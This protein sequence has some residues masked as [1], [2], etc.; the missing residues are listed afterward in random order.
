MAVNSSPYGA[1]REGTG[2][3]TGPSPKPCVYC[4][5]PIPSSST[6]CPTCK[7]HQ[8]KWRNNLVLIAGLSGFLALM[9][10][11]VTF[12][13][14]R[15]IQLYK[16]THWRDDVALLALLTGPT[17]EY[18]A[19]LSNNGDGAIFV[20]DLLI[21]WRGDSTQI[22]INK[23]IE[24]GSIVVMDTMK[25]T[26]PMYQR[27]VAN[28]EGKASLQLLQSARIWADPAGPSPPC[29]LAHVHSED[30]TA[31]RMMD[32]FY[33]QGGRRLVTDKGEANLEYF[34]PHL[35]IKNRKVFPITIAFAGSTSGNCQGIRTD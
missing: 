18:S 26:G 3:E 32:A 8:S 1:S 24:A 7:F 19:V 12:V 33:K 23:V 6:I 31:I 34:S 22:R 4:G 17:G 35:K 16:N 10:S 30:S 14:D 13:A 9:A 25:Y 28:L 2:S 29:F 11:A 5:S 21:Y 20:I 27:I 15:S